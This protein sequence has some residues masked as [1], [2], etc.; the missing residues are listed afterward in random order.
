MRVLA[1][2]SRGL[3]YRDLGLEDFRAWVS[4]MGGLAAFFQEVGV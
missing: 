4:R 2:I 1:L 3:Q